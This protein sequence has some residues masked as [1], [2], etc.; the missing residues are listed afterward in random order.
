[1]A[2][3]DL[4]AIG[5]S[6]G[7]VEALLLL[8]RS[9]PERFPASVLVTLHIGTYPR[10]TLDDV[11]SRAGP[12]PATFAVEGERLRKSHIYIAPPDRHLLVVGDHLHLGYGPRENNTRP[13]IDP[14]LRSAAV[15]RGPRSVGVVLTGTLSDGASGL[16]ALDQCGGLTV[17]QD[18]IDAAFPEM[19]MT[20]MNQ[21]HPDHV[22]R[23]AEM[24]QL[25]NS[26]V[27]EPAGP[28]RP[29]PESF[30]YEVE[31]ARTGNSSMAE[32]DRFGRRSVL[33]CPDCGGVMWEID[34]GDLMRFRCHVGHTYS[35]ELLNVAL[36][37]NLRR[38]LASA[39]RALEERL[40][41]ATKLEKQAAESGHRLL[42][43]NWGERVREYQGE[44][45]V[46]RESIRR[47][48]EIAAN[49]AAN[50]AAA[51]E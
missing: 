3:R 27:H 48:D 45:G 7:G 39:R 42:T 31:V 14:M 50:A 21:A 51:A 5:T 47:M 34:E 11:L 46:I 44:L 6:A 24:P 49:S 43:E 1:M 19:P 4:V 20:A 41:L 10:S 8:A 38:A 13:A 18:P 32:M 12:L 29:V 16:W 33:S 37:E 25:L 26:L 30:K 9:F 22:V 35:A 40:A 23:L 28:P 15:C 17:V 2:N 36:D